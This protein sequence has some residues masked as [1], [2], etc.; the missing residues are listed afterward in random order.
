MNPATYVKRY[1]DPARGLAARAHL[2]WLARLG[3]GVRLPHAHP[4]APTLLVLEHLPG[5]H[6]EPGDLEAVAAT[7]GRLHGTAYAR[8]LRGARLDQPFTADGLTIADFHTGRHA[9]LDELGIDVTGLPVALYKD[10]NLRNVLITDSGPAMVDFDDLTLAPFG[11]DLAKLVVSTAMTHGRI[12]VG[13][14]DAARRA[15]AA[16]VETTGGLTSA[17][18][19]DQLAAY[20]EIHHR[21]TARYL[22]H[23]GYQ[24]PW[25]TVRPWPEPASVEGN[26]TSWPS[27]PNSSS[28]ATARPSATPPASPV[29]STAAPG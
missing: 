7:L 22:H 20:T 3:S 16:N 28:L 17:C 14:I 26:P 18:T 13:E 27:P 24:H 10:T 11:Y 1:T 21:L 4:G 15:Y 12:P 25:P 23:H 6:T 8:H 29:A 9:V 19:A 2:A 5:R